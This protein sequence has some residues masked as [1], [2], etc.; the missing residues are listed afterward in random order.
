MHA[1]DLPGD[2]IAFDQEMLNLR[3]KA[4]LPTKK[5]PLAT[6]QKVTQ[7]PQARQE[8]EILETFKQM[9][10][11]AKGLSRFS[12]TPEAQKI[13]DEKKKEREALVKKAD[14]RR[15]QTGT[16][17]W[18][19]S[20]WSS[21][22]GSGSP[23]RPY[24]PSSG[25]YAPTYGGYS[26]YGSG[27]P[28]QGAGSY[29]PTTIKGHPDEELDDDDKDEI[30]KGPHKDDEKKPTYSKSSSDEKKD[31]AQIA[32]QK[33]LNT[34]KNA[35]SAI[36]NLMTDTPKDE[37]LQKLAKQGGKK[38]INWLDKVSTAQEELE[39]FS[40]E[41]I[42]A[43]EK[44]DE[45]KNAKGSLENTLRS[46]VPHALKVIEQREKIDDITQLLKR[47][48]MEKAIKANKD[49]VEATAARM[50][51]KWMTVNKAEHDKNLQDL[52]TL[53]TQTKT[54]AVPG[55]TH[56]DKNAIKAHFEKEKKD[57]DEMQKLLP[58]PT[59]TLSNRIKDIDTTLKQIN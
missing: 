39:V 30:D 35:A 56:P 45:Y 1:F 29:A 27:Y 25:S 23:Y 8:Q 20:S 14:D 36:T 49:A 11:I 32:Y 10:S 13:I 42:K 2:D 12:T 41:K 4:Q 51:K 59:Q 52:K 37:I 15:K 24:R 28:S 53:Q 44:N 40:S 58:L 9:G 26:T 55:T 3:A 5:A 17:P 19:R 34:T 7:S 33:A 16:R 18:G 38:I 46:I 54:P 48:D 43:L 21:G 31:E 6:P 47:D 57:I 50:L 22:S